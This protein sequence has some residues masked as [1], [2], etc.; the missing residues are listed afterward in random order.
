VR[1]ISEKE[2]NHYKEVEERLRK[3][4][5]EDFKKKKLGLRRKAG[6]IL[7][8]IGGIMYLLNGIIFFAAFMGFDYLI[9]G[10]ISL[11][12]IILI[13]GFEKIKLGSVVILISIPISI[14][15]TSSLMRHASSYF[16][17]YVLNRFGFFLI[18][19]YPIPFP[20]SVLVIIGGVLCLKSLDKESSE[21]ENS[22]KIAV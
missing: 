7:S 18:S 6:L 12:G 22:M 21:R 5:T 19:L 4:I 16:F 9:I 10:T 1:P 17:F 14:V 3:E 13:K 15:V 20:T 11:I 2:H 8:G